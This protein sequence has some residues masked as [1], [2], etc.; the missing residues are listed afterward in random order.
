MSDSLSR[1]RDVLRL[2]TRQSAL[3]LWQARRVRDLIAERRPSLKIEFVLCSSEGDQNQKP[4]EEIFAAPKPTTGLFTKILDD[5]L[6]DGRADI[7]VH[8]LKDYPTQAP[9]G[10]CLV[11][12]PERA[13]VAD[14]LVIPREQAEL[15]PEGVSASDGA[16][17]LAPRGP[18]GTS[19]PRRINQL[20]ALLADVSDLRVGPIRG[21][22]GT[23]LDKLLRGDY[24]ALVMAEA[25]LSRL[26]PEE[27]PQ[28]ADIATLR[29]DPERE[30]LPAPG[31]GALGVGRR[32]DD[33]FAAELLAELHNDNAAAE[34]VAE[35][36][37]LAALGGGCFVPIGA[38]GS[39]DAKTGRLSLRG[40]VAAPADDAPDA[41][42]EVV[43]G[44]ASASNAELPAALGHKL[45]R[46]LMTEGA[47]DLVERI[48]QV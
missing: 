10:L 1:R 21:N 15:M 24:S 30:M 31:Q 35:R 38:L 11:C 2:A 44:A 19:S 40:R 27:C 16:R 4:F 14:V 25:G 46:Q 9:P 47:A 29:F 12:V 33:V 5:A 13:A 37:F 28:L 34:V 22:V 20:R 23:R 32:S 48:R 26:S 18:V 8:S 6:L 7:A 45:A 3:A 17:L 36:M 43:E 41:K 42:I 39:L